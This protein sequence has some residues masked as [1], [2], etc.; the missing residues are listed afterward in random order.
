MHTHARVRVRTRK[1]QIVCG[2]H[3]PALRVVAAPRGGRRPP[4]GGPA[5]ARIFL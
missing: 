5:P 3:A 4:R 1:P 2:P